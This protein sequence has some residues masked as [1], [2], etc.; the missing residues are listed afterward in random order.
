MANSC[1]SLPAHIRKRSRKGEKMRGRFKHDLS[2][3]SAQPP[4]SISSSMRKDFA[5][6]SR[7]VAYCISA[8]AWAQRHSGEAISSP[9]YRTFIYFVT[10]I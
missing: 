8:C 4:P 6:T 3:K 2:S 9:N 1:T 10:A 5:F 7:R